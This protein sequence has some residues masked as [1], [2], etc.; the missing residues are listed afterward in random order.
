[1][2]MAI[3]GLLTVLFM[4][5]WVWRENQWGKERMM[6]LNRLMAKNLPEYNYEQRKAEVLRK[7]PEAKPV[8]SDAELA[9]WERKHQSQI[10]EN[11]AALDAALTNLRRKAVSA[12]PEHKPA[13]V[14]H[15]S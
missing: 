7:K 10:A 3:M 9:D 13:G 1:M 5:A 14:S 2:E 6:L 4:L 8:A 15:G 11:S 12:V